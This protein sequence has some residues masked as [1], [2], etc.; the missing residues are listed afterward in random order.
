ML[1]PSA[2]LLF[3]SCGEDVFLSRNVEIKRPELVGIG[4]H[5]AIDPY[6]YCTTRLWVGNHVHIASHVSVTG[7]E[8]GLFVVGD[9]CTVA[10]GCRIIC[11]SDSFDGS[12]LVTAPGIREEYLNRKVYG[13]VVMGDFSSLASNVIVLPYVIIGEGAVVGAGSFVDKDIPPWEV[14]VDSPARFLKKRPSHVMK[15]YA[16]RIRDG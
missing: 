2:P 5:V 13:T 9:F 15:E 14:W 4:S 16:K 12:G 6:F 3:Q 11:S 8:K 7:G 1:D 10:A